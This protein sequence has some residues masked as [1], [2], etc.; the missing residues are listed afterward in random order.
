[1]R[2]D[3]SDGIDYFVDLAVTPSPVHLLV[4]CYYF[5]KNI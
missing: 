5:S 4:I 3:C 1:M 2:E